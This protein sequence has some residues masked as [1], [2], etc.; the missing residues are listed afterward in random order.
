M[1][2]RVRRCTSGSDLAVPGASRCPRQLC[3]EITGIILEGKPRRIRP[4]RRGTRPVHPG[5]RGASRR[6]RTLPYSVAQQV[7]SPWSFAVSGT[8]AQVSPRV[9]SRASVG[10]VCRHSV[11]VRARFPGSVRRLDAGTGAV[12]NDSDTTY[13]TASTVVV[14]ERPFAAS[15]PAESRLPARWCGG[16]FNAVEQPIAVPCLL[17]TQFQSRPSSG[18]SG[19]SWRFPS[20]TSSRRGY[21]GQ[22][23][24]PSRQ[25]ARHHR[26]RSRI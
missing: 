23:R 8:P 18:Q 7:P 21:S 9:R 24:C 15:P 13:Q 17:R 2:R 11:D 12:F 22:R 4:V 14:V 26:T 20:L 1:T 19:R 25:T 16:L 6:A 5:R 3:P 10:A